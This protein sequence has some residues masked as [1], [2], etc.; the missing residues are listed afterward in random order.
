MEAWKRRKRCNRHFGNLLSEPCGQSSPSG[1]AWPAAGSESCV[2]MGRPIRQSVDSQCQSRV[3]EPRKFIAVAFLVVRMGAVSA[4]R[5][6][7][8]VADPPGSQSRA[9]AHLRFPRNMGDP[10]VST[11]TD[12]GRRYRVTNSRPVGEHPARRERNDR[13][14]PVVS[15]NE[16]KRSAARR[17]AGSRSASIVPTKPG[18]S[19][20]R[21]HGGGKRGV[22]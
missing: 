5:K 15:P 16:G 18:N 22:R 12:P 10:A 3:I 21:G 20:R 17:A 7:P 8:D 11:S 4:R 9:K 14:P 6:W 2:A 19:T 1:R 13:G